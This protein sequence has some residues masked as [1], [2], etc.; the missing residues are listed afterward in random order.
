MRPRGIRGVPFGRVGD[1]NRV[2]REDYLAGCRLTL[3]DGT[4][5]PFTKALKAVGRFAVC[6]D[7]KPAMK[8]Q[9][10]PPTISSDREGPVVVLPD[11]EKGMQS[12]VLIRGGYPWLRD[13]D[14]DKR[15]VKELKAALEKAGKLEAEK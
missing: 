13:G 8:G 6:I 3:K 15:D 12:K 5:V 14:T 10:V 11:G 9:F 1:D 7:G 4:K 2:A